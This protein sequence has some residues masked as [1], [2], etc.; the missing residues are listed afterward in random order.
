MYKEHPVSESID[1]FS[2]NPAWE[3]YFQCIKSLND[4]GLDVLR[5]GQLVDGAIS[6]NIS[7]MIDYASTSRSEFG[8]VWLLANCKFVIAG[9]T[10][11]HHLPAAFNLPVVISD[12]YSVVGSSYGRLDLVVYQLAWSRSEK[13]LMPFSWM[14]AEKSWAQIK[15]LIE[16]D[17]EIIKNTAEEINEVVLEMN[18]RLDGTWIESDEDIELQYR[19]KRL[20][21]V[22]PKNRVQEGVRIGADFLRRYQ[23]LL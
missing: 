17:I 19:F 16:F 14:F 4:A 18:Q 1:L 9:G 22:L 21:D 7:K 13:R 15:S 23:H 8:D 5:M 10:G 20:R 3:S 6:P 11:I 2:A 12:A